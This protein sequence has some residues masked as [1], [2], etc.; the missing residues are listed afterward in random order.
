MRIVFFLFLIF[1]SSS[2]Q[3]LVVLQYHHVS[4][5]TPKT[6][7]ISPQL[8]AAHLDYLAKVNI[9]VIK[10]ERLIEIL[11][12]GETLPDRTAI[13]T[14][15]DGYR[16]IFTHAYPL[17]KK[18]GWPFT[19]FVNSKAHDEKSPLHMSWDDLKLM[20]K[21]GAMIANH[22]DSHSHLIRRR[23]QEPF[24]SWLKRRELEIT[25]AQDRID[26]EIGK[27]FKVLA[28]PYGEF[29]KELLGQLKT[30]GYIAFGQQSGP[31]AKSSQHQSLPRFPFGG[32][33]GDMDD[34]AVKVNSLPFP[35]SRIN[36]LGSND[37]VIDEPELPSDTT[38]PILRI[39]SPLMP[40]INNLACYASGQ[41]KIKAEIN[42]GVL[43]AQAQRALP[44]GRSRY[45][46]TASAGGGRYYWYSQL[47]IRRA[48]NGR[49]AHD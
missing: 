29:D 17:L 45:N 32:V 39:A 18:R 22:T 7:S 46:C 44:I 35:S 2:L 14:F 30:M 27:S 12:R 10:M 28:H 5:K 26:K 24:K 4:T 47:F 40:Y 11:K 1:I 48:A 25:F 41:N 9:Q 23:A 43:V 49:W 33:Y 3:A 19:V 6:T 34:F 42:G 21:N 20:S 31:V 8:F 37:K 13:I 36:V 38:Q 15:D 16:S